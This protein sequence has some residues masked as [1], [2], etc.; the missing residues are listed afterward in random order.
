MT[1]KELVEQF[2]LTVAAGK[3]GLDREIKGGHCGDL[4]S[5]VMA[6]APVGCIWFTIQVHQNVVAVA[7]L[8]EMAAIILT[9]GNSPD[10]ETREK[11]D[12][13]SI[14]ILLS[15]ETTYGLAG[16]CYAAGITN[17]SPPEK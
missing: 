6:N 11:A 14:P 4:L 5:E 9:G 10:A 17:P 8:K 16:K 13:E 7:L 15:S 1:A 3:E 2:G 12:Q